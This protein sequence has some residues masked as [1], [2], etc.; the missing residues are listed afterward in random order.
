MSSGGDHKMLEI[1]QLRGSKPRGAGYSRSFDTEPV[2]P[3][4]SVC[5]AVFCSI[6]LLC[7]HSYL[8]EW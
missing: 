3:R 4:F 5:P 6:F 1:P 7:P 2:G 8:L